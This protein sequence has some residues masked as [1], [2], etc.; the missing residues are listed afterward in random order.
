MNYKPIE[1][2]DRMESLFEQELSKKSPYDVMLWADTT[3]AMLKHF[4]ASD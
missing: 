1:M 4:G 2:L 3:K